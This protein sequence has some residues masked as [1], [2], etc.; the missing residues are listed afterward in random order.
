VIL[1]TASTAWHLGIRLTRM[2]ALASSGPRPAILLPGR[3]TN[4]LNPF[5]GTVCPCEVGQDLLY[6]HPWAISWRAV[7]L[8][9]QGLVSATLLL[10]ERQAGDAK[11]TADEKARRVIIST[12]KKCAGTVVNFTVTSSRQ[13]RTFFHGQLVQEIFKINKAKVEK[14]TKEPSPYQNL[15]PL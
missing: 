3:A 14:E 15:E 10:P 11:E 7:E 12:A 8:A 13:P 5:A 6:H 9:P 1:V 2:L 4:I